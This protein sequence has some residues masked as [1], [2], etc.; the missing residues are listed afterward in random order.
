MKNI[1][2]TFLVSLLSGATAVACLAAGTNIALAQDATVAPAN[3]APPAASAPTSS[4]SS[5]APGLPFGAAEVLKMYKGGVGKDIIINYIN[6]TV[7]PFHLSADGIIYLQSIGLPQ[8]ITRTMIQRD[9]Q[10]QQQAAAAYQQQAY[11]QQAYQQYQQQMTASDQNAAAAQQVAVPSTPPP[12]VAVV[13]SD[14]NPYYDY[15][16]PYGYGYPYYGSSVIIGGGWGGWGWGG[17]PGF[18]GFRGGFGGFRG[19]FGGFRGGGGGFHGGFGG[20]HGGGGGH[21]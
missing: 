19:G 12:S 4:M 15:G 1:R 7:L 13:G 20:G 9:G 16:Y 6:S 8:D 5:P 14:A 18:G 3:S 11:Q 10:L 21:R 2:S 17:Y